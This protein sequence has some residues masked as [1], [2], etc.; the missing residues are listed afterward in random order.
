MPKKSPSPIRLWSGDTTEKKMIGLT[1]PEIILQI[2][3][4]GYL[5][6]MNMRMR[7]GN[8]NNIFD[9]LKS[10]IAFFAVVSLVAIIH[11][12]LTR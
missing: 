4:F 12:L 9:L 1:S 3:K 10:S 2:T 6:F 7:D 8:G 5:Q 11:A